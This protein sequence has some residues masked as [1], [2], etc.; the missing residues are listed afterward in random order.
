MTRISYVC[1][2]S[3][4][5]L[6][7]L[8]LFKPAQSQSLIEVLKGQSIILQD[9]TTLYH[10][11]YKPSNKETF[12]I[13]LIRTPY[14]KE[15]I[16]LFGNFFAEEGFGVVI[17]DVRGKYSSKGMFIPFFKEYEDGLQ[18]LDWIQK[19]TWFDGN[20]GM[21][22]SSYLGFSA[23]ILSK[24]NHPALKSIFNL[25]GW[26]DGTEISETDGA[27]H[28]LLVIPWLL[29][30]GQKT[31]KSLKGMDLDEIFLH[32]PLV[33]VM[34]DIEFKDNDG[35]HKLEEI[36]RMYQN[37][38]HEQSAV[39]TMHVNGWFDFTLKASLNDYQMLASKASSTQKMILGPWYHNQLYHE[40]PMLG[41]YELPENGE[42]NMQWMLD[43]AKDWFK[44]TLIDSYK[45]E[46]NLI[47]YYVLFK[48]TWNETEIWPPKNSVEANYYLSDNNLTENT[49]TN[50][51]SIFRGFTF[52]P[53]NPVPTTG[54]ANFHTFLEKMGIRDQQDV[55]SRED[56][57]TFSTDPFSTDKTFAG[58]HSVTLYVSTTGI[59][60]DFTAKLTKVDS[61]GVSWNLLDAITRI[62]PGALKLPVVKVTLNLGDMAFQIKKGESIRL[63]VSSSN[64]PKYN[65]NPNSGVE[66]ILAKE[67][68]PAQQR[69][70]FSNQYPSHIKLSLL[71]N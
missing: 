19:Q 58:N 26:I 31:R 41:D 25:S 35:L 63:Q 7:G 34:P 37:Y 60:T 48:D 15:G 70:Y 55:E 39:P 16:E 23:M 32:T 44:N 10:D 40:N 2:V 33:D 6:A 9:G 57:L 11:F 50:S 29:F 68:K 53:H 22:G 69:I 5:F 65:R 38:P 36:T 42:A 71:Q 54:G 17:Q 56:V 3:C 66:S 30:E 18:T 51:N 67:L 47:R 49:P 24:S 28:Q 46:P 27:F 1:K 8:F 64:F 4:F 12:P 61:A 45:T 43:E 59:G 14:Q 62:E 20:V 52:D 13:I 21:W